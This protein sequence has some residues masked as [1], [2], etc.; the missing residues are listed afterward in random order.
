MQ[1]NQNQRPKQKGNLRF[2]LISI[3]LILCVFFFVY[4]MTQPNPKNLTYAELTTAVENSYVDTSTLTAQPVGG[5]N[6]DM[7][8]V[9]GKIKDENGNYITFICVI[10]PLSIAFIG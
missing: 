7:F 1:N 8:E 5:Q 9:N 4:H 3:I 6:Y 10:T 2:I